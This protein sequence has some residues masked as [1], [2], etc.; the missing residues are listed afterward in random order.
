MLSNTDVFIRSEEGTTQGDRLSMLFF[1]VALLPSIK[2]I[3]E[4][5]ETTFFADHAGAERGENIQRLAR[6]NISLLLR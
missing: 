4:S 6:K 2:K 5:D 3:A 1:G